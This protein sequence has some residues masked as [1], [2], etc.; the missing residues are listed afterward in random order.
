MGRDWLQAVLARKI[1][2][3]RLWQW[4]CEGWREASLDPLQWAS[5]LELAERIEGPAAFFEAFASVLLEGT[6]KEQ[7]KLPM[8]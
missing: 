6:R 2:D 3:D 5:V 8:N 4:V 1:W 7:N